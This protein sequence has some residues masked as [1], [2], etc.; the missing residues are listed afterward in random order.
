MYNFYLGELKGL[1]VEY[2]LGLFGWFFL[3]KSL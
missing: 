1:R 2:V 3:N